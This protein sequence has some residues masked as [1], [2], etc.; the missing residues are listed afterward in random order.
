MWNRKIYVLLATVLLLMNTQLQAAN[1][2]YRCK[3]K[4]QVVY[5]EYPSGQC[6]QQPLKRLSSYTS[7]YQHKELG[8][9]ETPKKDVPVA[10][11]SSGNNRQAL[12]S[13]SA[14]D[15]ARLIGRRQI[16]NQELENER[17]ALTAAQK[18][19]AAARVVPKQEQ[20]DEYAAYQQKI[21]ELEDEVLD[22]QQNIRAL[23][24]ELN[25]M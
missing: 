20:L 3:V 2:V 21:S 17:K 9:P 1:R 25:R 10:T 16:L 18:R 8:Q 11:Q 14:T 24:R 7:D 4:G 19:L 6:A 23:Q 5:T 22:R 12:P 15:N 13:E